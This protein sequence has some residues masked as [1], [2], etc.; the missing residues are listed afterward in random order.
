MSDYN[1]LSGRIFQGREVETA[2]R[3]LNENAARGWDFV[4][5]LPIIEPK[6]PANPNR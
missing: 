1:I 3:W 5:V 4:S 2:N 6:A